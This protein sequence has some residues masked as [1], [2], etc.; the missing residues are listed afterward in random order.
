MVKPFAEPP[1]V[2]IRRPGPDGIVH[3]SEGR[4]VRLHDLFGRSFVALYFTDTRRRPDIPVNDLPWLTHCAVSRWDAPRGRRS[5]TGRC[6]TPVAVW[7]PLWLCARHHGLG[8]SGRPRCRDRA[9]VA[10]PRAVS[11]PGGS[12]NSP[13]GDG[14]GVTI[15]VSYRFDDAVILITGAGSGIGA[16]LA[17]HCVREG[18]AVIAVDRRHDA[19]LDGL[20]A[21][22]RRR[23]DVRRVDVA[24][25]PLLPR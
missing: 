7:P 3:D 2:E 17:R 4:Q 20:E 10:R 25:R 22:A 8:A 15:T 14:T 12:R 1:P 16:A 18:A 23:I 19:L 11:L 24:A 21:G 9:D 5:A 6:S 13:A